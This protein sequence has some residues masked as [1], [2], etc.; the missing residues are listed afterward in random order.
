MNLSGNTVLVTGGG[1]GIGRGLAEMFH[2]EGSRV[3]VTGRD[4]ARLAEVQRGRD[5]IDAMVLDLSDEQSTSRFAA[6]VI[7]RHPELNIVVHNSGITYHETIGKGDVPLAEEIIAV[8]LLGM[9]R[10]NSALL[11]FLTMQPH[12]TI[13][14]VSSGLAFLPIFLQPTYCASKAAVHSYT[15]SLRY[16]V[17]DSQLRVLELIPPYVQTQLGGPHQASDPDAMPLPVFIDEVADILR[18][19]PT[20]SEICVERVRVERQAESSGAYETLF[21]QLNDPIATLLRDQVAAG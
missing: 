6:E 9:I 20:P 1:R 17:Q 4:Q 16:Q 18:A 10:L 19:D 21:R 3:I 5:G 8:N 14:T 11:P 7:E 2:A 15:Q 13:I 12:G